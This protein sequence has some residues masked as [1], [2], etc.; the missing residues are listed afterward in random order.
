MFE[1]LCLSMAGGILGLFLAWIA[2]RL[3]LQL[4]P[5]TLPRAGEVKVD[6]LI[7]LTALGLA[8]LMGL[9][10]GLVPAFAATR[11]NIID[12]LKET[13]RTATV[14]GF[15]RLRRALVMGEIAVASILLTAAGVFILSFEKM[16][17]V[18]LGFQP[19]N[20]IVASYYLPPKSYSTQ[21]SIN[22]FNEDLLQKLKAAAE[23][24]SSGLATVLP[25]SGNSDDGAI[26][27]EGGVTAASA[28]PDLA[29]GIS[30][31][32]DYF[33]AMGIRLLK[34]RFLN[35]H[36]EISTETSAVVSRNLA[37]HEWPGQDP[38]GK[39]IK[40]GTSASNAPWATVVGEV[41]DVPLGSPDAPS[42]QQYYGP[43][44]QLSAKARV[45]AELPELIN[46]S[47]YLVVKTSR[48]P[49]EVRLELERLV[50]EMDPE[51]PLTHL[52]TMEEALN[53]SEAPRKFNTL[54][55]SSFAIL[56]LLM[57][58][59]GI[60]GITALSVEM[61]THEMAIRIALGTPRRDI[62][63]MIISSGLKLACAGCFIGL[64][65][66]VATSHLL[67][68]QLYRVSPLDPSIFVCAF[69]AMLLLT[70]VA[71]ILPAYRASAA[72]I[73]RVLWNQ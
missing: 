24:R 63:L 23:I 64:I 59:G 1:S 28:A 46:N 66:S 45:A 21:S 71:C 26:T 14:V 54:L 31:K 44:K 65:G 22:Q 35:V 36:D 30:I 72:D 17:E 12:V 58:M 43:I 37:N 73:R 50:H 62:I 42:E 13:G 53:G 4:L 15:T 6:W 33:K 8:T 48:S 55:L 61:R 56:S 69:L 16:R 34:G 41:D 9:I 68:S 51:L 5:E 60:Y 57:A 27:V 70:A 49:G 67:K 3:G 29:M 38:I 32:G 39:R 25:V 2:I 47:M 18:N 7:G 19:D 40:E 20:C 11:T 10:C 52:Q